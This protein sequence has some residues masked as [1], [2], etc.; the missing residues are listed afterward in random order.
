MT[1][2]PSISLLK[3]SKVLAHYLLL[4]SLEIV[5]CKFSRAAII[6][7]NAKKLVKLFDAAIEDGNQCA[8]VLK[9]M[10]YTGMRVG[11]IESALG[12]QTKVHP[13]LQKKGVK[14]VFRQTF[15]V[16]TLE[17]RH[18]TVQKNKVVFD[19]LGKKGVQQSIEVNDPILVSQLKA[20]YKKCEDTLFSVTDCHVR[21]YVKNTLGETF[22]VKDFRTMYANAIA[23]SEVLKYKGELTKKIQKAICVFVASKLGNTPAISRKAYIDP[24]ILNFQLN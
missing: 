5:N 6:A 23:T 13:M 10:M 20:Q 9:L 3:S 8:L 1:H 4:R 18:I 11:N 21:E 17:K 12:Y 24:A 19:F 7:K 14:S 2:L 16:T 22:M 15:G